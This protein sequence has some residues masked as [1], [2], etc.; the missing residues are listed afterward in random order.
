MWKF[1]LELFDFRFYIFI[2]DTFKFICPCRYPS[3]RSPS[4]CI[5]F[6]IVHSEVHSPIF[7]PTF[8][9]WC[10]QGQISFQSRC[11]AVWVSQAH[12]SFHVSLGL[13]GGIYG[14]EDLTAS[15]SAALG[16]FHASPSQQWDGDWDLAWPPC[17]LC[18]SPLSGVSPTMGGPQEKLARM[19]S[20]DTEW[21]FFSMDV[22]NSK[23]DTNMKDIRHLSEI[24]I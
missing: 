1:I 22:L 20:S 2:S 15:G 13:G 17:L 3:V 21:I 7:S 14:S 24:L 4:L 9:G 5:Y 10:F 8:C 6:L 18:S 16:L 12:A 23:F 19:P 11:R